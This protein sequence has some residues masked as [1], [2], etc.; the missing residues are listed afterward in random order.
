MDNDTDAKNGRA[1]CKS[2]DRSRP[3]QTASGADGYDD[4][5]DFQ[6]FQQHGLECS[7]AGD[8]IERRVSARDLGQLG[9]SDAKM[10]SSS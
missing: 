10:A 6:S 7:Q 4:E 2:S 5:N 1:R 3:Q 8:P 9:V